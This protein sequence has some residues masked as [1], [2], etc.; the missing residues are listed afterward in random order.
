[1]KYFLPGFNL[2]ASTNV[3]KLANKGYSE[4]DMQH[5]IFKYILLPKDKLT[6]YIFCGGGFGLNDQK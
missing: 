5:L 1:L 3:I 6:P 2:S 4:K